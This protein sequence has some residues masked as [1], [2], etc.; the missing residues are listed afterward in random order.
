MDK[1]TMWFLIFLWAIIFILSGALIVL[2][3][4]AIS[5]IYTQNPI[6]AAWETKE[7]GVFLMRPS[8]TKW[9]KIQPSNIDGEM[10]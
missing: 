8:S 7:G 4:R 5:C 10:K 6:S 3:V 1:N 9:E 2:S